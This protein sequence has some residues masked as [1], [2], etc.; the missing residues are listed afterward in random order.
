MTWR[1]WPALFVVNS[2]SKRIYNLLP[3]PLCKQSSW[4]NKWLG[5]RLESTLLL[6]WFLPMK[7]QYPSKGPTDQRFVQDGA[8]GG[9]RVLSLLHHGHLSA[10]I[11]AVRQAVDR[12]AL[13]AGADGHGGQRVGALHAVDCAC[14]QHVLLHVLEVEVRWAKTAKSRSVIKEQSVTVSLHS[15][16][17]IHPG[18]PVRC[19]STNNGGEKAAASNRE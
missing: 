6:E 2:I 19:T 1:F 10:V 15:V 5:D 16:C 12:A 7:T 11:W 4:L 9:D 14:A 13:G 8:V 18:E 3:L 17:Y